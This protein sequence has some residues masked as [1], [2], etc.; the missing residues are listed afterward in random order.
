MTMPD[1]PAGGSK[2]VA[3]I[4]ATNALKFYAEQ[5][6]LSVAAAL[7]STHTVGAPVVDADGAYLGFIN[8]WDVMKALDLG[9]DLWRLQAQDIMRKD[10]LVITP[11][12]TIAEAA[13]IM[14]QHQVL[15]LPVERDGAVAYS[16]S[17]HDLLRARIGGHWEILSRD[18]DFD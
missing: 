10:R 17:Q 9:R 15:N 13:K 7:L 12:T 1:L 14:E 5:N 8:E 4:D 3:Q 16:V 6:G 11:L 2:T 18:V